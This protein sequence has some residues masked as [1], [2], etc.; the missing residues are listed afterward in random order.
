M[1][2]GMDEFVT[3]PIDNRLLF[4]AL[5]RVCGKPTSP[6]ATAAAAAPAPTAPSGAGAPADT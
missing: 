4:A 3:K 2:A 1:A 5:A 6:P